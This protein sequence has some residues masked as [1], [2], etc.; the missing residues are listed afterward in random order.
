MLAL[1]QHRERGRRFTSPVAVAV[2]SN[3]ARS[4]SETREIRGGQ[5]SPAVL[6][7][8]RQGAGR[9]KS[10]DGGSTSSTR[11]VVRRLGSDRSRELCVLGRNAELDTRRATSQDEGSASVRSSLSHRLLRKR[12]LHPNRDAELDTRST[13]CDEGS[14]CS[15]PS[16]S[17]RDP[18]PVRSQA[19]ALGNKVVCQDG[20]SNESCSQ[21]VPQER[22][23]WSASREA[24]TLSIASFV[25]NAIPDR[26]E[27]LTASQGREGRPP[28]RQDA[29]ACPTTSSSRDMWHRRRQARALA[30]RCTA[31]STLCTDQKIGAR[32]LQKALSPSCEEQRGGRTVTPQN[33][34][35][36]DRGSLDVCK[37]GTAT[38]WSRDDEH[39]WPHDTL[40]RHPLSQYARNRQTPCTICPSSQCST[41]GLE[42]VCAPS[43][44]VG[45]TS[46]IDVPRR[47]PSHRKRAKLPAHSRWS[48]PRARLPELGAQVNQVEVSERFGRLSQE[49]LLELERNTHDNDWCGVPNSSMLMIDQNIEQ[50][51]SEVASS[52]HSHFSSWA[53][54][55]SKYRVPRHEDT[56]EGDKR[57]AGVSVCEALSAR[58]TTSGGFRPGQ[59]LQHSR[60][61]LGRRE[62]VQSPRC[63]GRSMP[64]V[65]LP[66]HAPISSCEQQV[67][68]C[69]D[70]TEEEFSNRVAPSQCSSTD[71][72]SS[73]ARVND[74]NVHRPPQRA[75]HDEC[76]PTDPS[77]S[78]ASEELCAD[79]L[80]SLGEFL[81][82]QTAGLQSAHSAAEPTEN[83]TRSC[84][85]SKTTNEAEAS[86]LPYAR[87]TCRYTRPGETTYIGIRTA[88]PL[89]M[90]APRT[91]Q[92]LGD[93]ERSRVAGLV[94]RAV[95]LR[96]YSGDPE[97][98]TH[99]VDLLL[100]LGVSFALNHRTLL[101]C[102]FIT[103]TDGMPSLLELSVH[104]VEI[105]DIL[106][107]P[108][109]VSLVGQ[110]RL[111]CCPNPT[112]RALVRCQGT[113]L[114]MSWN[115]TPI[116][117]CGLFSVGNH[118][119]ACHIRPSLWKAGACWC[120]TRSSC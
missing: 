109:Q 9:V 44:L 105:L 72:C 83:H 68:A 55:F 32:G 42:A 30:G 86:S 104:I 108:E 50:S 16:R 98:R 52:T 12:E 8:Q 46:D 47:T 107:P 95:R 33:H 38:M 97:Y 90:A 117:L 96:E 81:A 79:A 77:P 13:S 88:A 70:E 92:E 61:S 20:S 28:T 89:K 60:R 101:K 51:V 2:S 102:G 80:P 34:D 39:A 69:W 22:G 59:E 116:S 26:T 71:V 4:R 27:M 112:G 82:G 15:K 23:G 100:D 115:C 5:R 66:V 87:A 19:A 37:V 6:G 3:A 91:V 111:S 17:R 21:R 118:P 10:R 113:D 31:S 58:S 119:S 106:V 67:G 73:T 94:G 78:S 41:L 11:S 29:E 103:T 7:M 93:F 53:R 85:E 114:L 120:S 18:L 110:S 76:I 24:S 1:A 75:W 35:E 40:R 57:D 54:C 43:Q 49:S 45:D 99:L 84:S 25:Q 14:V 64:D 63:R 62:D 48:M 65:M 74:L 36:H 56:S